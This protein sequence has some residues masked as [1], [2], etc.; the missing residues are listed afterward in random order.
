MS[1]PV[2]AVILDGP[3]P[4]LVLIVIYGIT[5]SPP[6]ARSARMWTSSR[7]AERRR[8]LTVAGLALARR[9]TSG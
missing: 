9:R 6:V 4:V 5:S 1:W 7:T 3:T 2:R 8:A